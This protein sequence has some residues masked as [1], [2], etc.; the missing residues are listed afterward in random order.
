M[1]D[2]NKNAIND[3]ELDEVT[4]GVSKGDPHGTWMYKFEYQTANG[5][6]VSVVSKEKYR[7]EGRARNAG[8]F[9]RL[10]FMRKKPSP[11]VVFEERGF[12]GG[13]TRTLD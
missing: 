4:G 13:S 8:T 7:T 2:L 9:A 10:K 1:E 12:G 5:R 6:F 11:L 3:D